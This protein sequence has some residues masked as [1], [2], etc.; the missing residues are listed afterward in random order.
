MASIKQIL[1]A[2]ENR[3]YP[4]PQRKWKYYQEWY[5]TV[6]FHWEVPSYLLEKY[7]PKEIQIDTY[8]GMAWVSLVSFEIKNM[9]L[10][11]LPMLPY[12][13]NFEEINIRTYVTKDGIPGIY[14]FSIE[15]NKLIE[16]LFSKLFIGLPYEKAEIKRSGNRLFSQNLKQ[17][18]LLDIKIG[19]TSSIQKTDLDVWLTERH[20]LYDICN[21]KI[22]RFDI[23]HKEW[24]ILDLEI[25][26][27]DIWYEAG[28]FII[29]TYPDRIHYT[30]KIEVLLWGK[31]EA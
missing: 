21:D 22:C 26:I 3:Q 27:K 6:F 24:E 13:S 9:R 14:L 8:A 29:N 17:N 23:H 10:R 2:T 25:R 19:K 30:E 5:H 4:L 18:H 12:I 1:N 20:S 28:D 7:I 15:T 31:K 16:V 11:Y